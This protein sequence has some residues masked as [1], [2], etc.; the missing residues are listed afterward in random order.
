MKLQ[1]KEV[2]DIFL[3]VIILWLVGLSG[4]FKSINDNV[5][6]GNV[7]YGGLILFVLTTLIMLIF[8]IK[9]NK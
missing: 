3:Y 8:F 7:F 9:K 5:Y 4:V 6:E 2:D 1:F